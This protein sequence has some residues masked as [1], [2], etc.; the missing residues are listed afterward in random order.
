MARWRETQ[1]RNRVRY[2]LSW[3][4]DRGLSRQ[5]TVPA[6]PRQEP[7][8]FLDDDQRS[9]LLH[10]CL[11]DQ[12]LPIEARAAGALILLFALQAQHIRHL[13]ADQLTENSDDT[14]LTVGRHPILLPPRLGALLR[15]LASRPS[16]PLMIPHGPNTPGRGCQV[17]G[18]NVVRVFPCRGDGGLCAWCGEAAVE[19]HLEGVEGGFP[20]VG[21]ALLAFPGRVE[22]HHGEVE[23]LHRGLLVREVATG[24]D[25]P[26]EPGVEA[27][28]RY[29]ESRRRLWL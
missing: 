24:V 2:F 4:A 14:Y 7:A 9:Q 17:N 23:D 13:T 27:L 18:G 20:A 10:R 5:L 22:A 3:T 29:L 1:R 21:P 12:A 25:R 15:N 16:T 19:G 8:E 11:T 28:D 26:T 6:I